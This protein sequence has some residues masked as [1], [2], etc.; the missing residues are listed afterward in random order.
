MD[1]CGLF[2]GAV[3][4]KTKLATE[5][6]KCK[7]NL[8]VLL[9]ESV[10]DEKLTIF[11]TGKANQPRCFKNVSGDSFPVTCTVNKAA[12]IQWDIHWVVEYY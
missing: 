8:T 11:V 6:D 4:D 12:W 9:A 1:E 2:F 5:W 10:M 3:P 7:R